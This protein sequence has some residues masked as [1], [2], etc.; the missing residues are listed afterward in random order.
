MVNGTMSDLEPAFTIH[1]SS[2]V[3]LTPSRESSPTHNQQVAA[4]GDG[5]VVVAQSAEP[6]QK[7]KRGRQPLTQVHRGKE[8]R[9][10]ALWVRTVRRPGLIQPL[11]LRINR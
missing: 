11:I 3:L 6:E 9:T 10:L 1:P 8:V 2:S 4:N 7:G 5:G